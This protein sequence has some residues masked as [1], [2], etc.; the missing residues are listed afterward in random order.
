MGRL[1]MGTGRRKRPTAGKLFRFDR[2]FGARYV[3]GVDEAGRGSLAGPLVAAGVLLDLEEMGAAERRALAWLNDSKQKS[4]EEREALFP[5]VIR[6][7]TRVSVS[8]HSVRAI[9]SR[10]LHKSNLAALAIC[11]RR[12]AVP[13]AICLSDGFR[14]PCELEHT[15][16]VD[17]DAKSAA[18][19]AASVI[20]KVSRDRY[21][22]RA[23][24]L[25]PGWG[26]AG[27]A[28]YSTPDHREAI[29][30]N[31]ISPLHRRSFASVA[32]SQLSLGGDPRAAGDFSTGP[33][34]D[35][36]P[37]AGSEGGA[38]VIDLDLARAQKADADDVEAVARD[39]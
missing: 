11:M 8:V 18:I 39:A 29:L 20:A 28:G 4:R 21:M 5:H 27:N 6:A 23:D 34:E 16:V 33:P 14:V 26:F 7:A 19:A 38:D 9:D 3:V 32:Y 13:G 35:G 31:G 37:E 22:C 17:G 30:A 10:G 12:A 36:S 24:E 2:S 15:A 25:H 1:L